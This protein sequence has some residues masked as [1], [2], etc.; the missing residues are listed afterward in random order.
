MVEYKGIT[1]LNTYISTVKFD[2]IYVKSKREER[3]SQFLQCS[4]VNSS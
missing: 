4:F 3:E 1:E 2:F